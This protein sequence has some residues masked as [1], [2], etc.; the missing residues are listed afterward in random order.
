MLEAVEPLSFE[1]YRGET[2]GLVGESGSGKTTLARMLTGIIPPTC[3][4]FS[5]EGEIQMIFQEAAASFDSGIFSGEDIGR[6]IG[7]LEKTVQRRTEKKI[8]RML[9]LVRLEESISEKQQ[10]LFLEDSNSGQQ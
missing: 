3:G 6:A 10:L 9:Q 2:F 5:C 4:S 1:I 7:D 8:T